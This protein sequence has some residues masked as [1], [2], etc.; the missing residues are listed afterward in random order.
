M[1]VRTEAAVSPGPMCSFRACVRPVMMTLNRTSSGSVA[2]RMA[3]LAMVEMSCLIFSRA[4]R[5]EAGRAVREDPGNG[6]RHCAVAPAQYP[7][8]GAYEPCAVVREIILTSNTKIVIAYWL[9]K[10]PE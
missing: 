5:R 10:I 7:K 6:L 1:R 9:L 4:E 3:S 8:D 2:L